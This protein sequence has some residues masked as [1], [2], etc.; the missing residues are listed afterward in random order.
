MITIVKSTIKSLPDLQY[1]SAARAEADVVPSAKVRTGPS[2][3]DLGAVDPDRKYEHSF[4]VNND[5]DKLLQLR[6][7]QPDCD[8]ITL[9]GDSWEIA[10]GDSVDIHVAWKVPTDAVKKMSQQIRFHTNDPRKKSIAFGIGGTP[11]IRWDF[12]DEPIDSP[13]SK[14]AISVASDKPFVAKSLL[15]SQL[16]EHTA[17]LETEASSDAVVIETT[18]ATPEQLA[19]LDAKSGVIVT[20]KHMPRSGVSK[21]S[22]RIRLRVLDPES[23]TARWVECPFQGAFKPAVG[24]YGPEIDRTEGLAIGTVQTESDE[25]WSLAA[26]FWT[27]DAPKEPAVLDLQ[28]PSLEATI[29][30]LS[31]PSGAFKITIRL[32]D[33]AKPTVF[34]LPNKRGYISFGDAANPKTSNWMPLTGQIIAP[35]Q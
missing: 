8:C 17:V 31:R 9:K 34:N 24:F 10:P 6:L 16:Y 13:S 26:R 27:S 32:K 5:G 22:E 21:F 33:D 35:T 20:A 23:G 11:R 28:P 19:E 18:E 12:S 7:E 2:F 3:H 1:E 29:K 14:S 30:P 4:S 25:E 15:Y